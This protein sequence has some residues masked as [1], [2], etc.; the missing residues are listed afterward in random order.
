MKRLFLLFI[1]LFFLSWCTFK[2]VTLHKKDISIKLPAISTGVVNNSIFVS[3]SDPH[4]FSQ[5]GPLWISGSYYFNPRNFYLTNGNVSYILKAYSPIFNNF[6]VY[7]YDENNGA[8]AWIVVYVLRNIL[9]KRN[10][11]LL[12]NSYVK[13]H[14]IHGKFRQVRNLLINNLIYTWWYIWTWKYVVVYDPTKIKFSTGDLLLYSSDLWTAKEDSFFQNSTGV[15]IKTFDWSKLIDIDWSLKSRKEINNMLKPLE[16][17]KYKKVYIYYPRYWYR[18]WVLAL[19][20]SQ[21]WF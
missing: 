17:N 12:I 15:D 19:Y 10:V 9:H 16:L 4:I 6:P 3:V 18:S 11:S 2:Q 20:L 1:I 13:S 14:L 21:F 7:Y 8:Q 5:T